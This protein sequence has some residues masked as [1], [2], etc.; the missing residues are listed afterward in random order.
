[1]SDEHSMKADIYDDAAKLKV[2][3]LDRAKAH[4]SN[5][6]EMQK[7]VNGYAED[8]QREVDDAQADMDAFEKDLANEGLSLE[9]LL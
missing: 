8:A 2:G 4:L 3:R 9:E 1:M 6:L 5:M 7:T